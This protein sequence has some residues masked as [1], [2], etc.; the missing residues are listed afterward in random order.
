MTISHIQAS[1]IHFRAVLIA[2]A[3][4]LGL[5]IPDLLMAAPDYGDVSA[6]HTSFQSFLT[7]VSGYIKL[8]VA[9]SSNAEKFI[10]ATFFTLLIFR[11][12]IEL[13]KWA[14]D[15]ADLFDV[16]TVVLLGVIVR[17]FMDS[18]DYI[19]SMLL[20]L[21]GDVGAA[22]QMPIIGN[23]DVFFG[24]SYIHNLL[25]AITLPETS[26]LDDLKLVLLLAFFQLI[27]W[28]LSV[29]AFFCMAWGVYGFALAKLVGWF[30]I[31]LM[32]LE[33]TAQLFDGWFRFLVGFLI[34]SVIARANII[35]VLLLLTSYFGIPM[36]VVK[37]GQPINYAITI[38]GDNYSDLGGLAAMLIISVLALL[39]TGK[40]AMA[41][42]GGVGGFGGVAGRLATGGSMMM[43][44]AAAA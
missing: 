23:S 41:I 12:A 21:S 4:G 39:A 36:A 27:I 13:S 20:I 16:A 9:P 1:A 22:I 30:F 33:K 42:A 17:V 44:R 37:A 15:H 3:A 2:L 10:E 25:E 26:I 40:F 7:N 32:L 8:V 11:L 29:M 38:S 35:L 31:P 18:Y 24:V 43:R 19:T 28:G 5:L 6:S 34:Y 14:F